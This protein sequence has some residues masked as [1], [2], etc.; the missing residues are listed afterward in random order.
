MIYEVL[1][2]SYF[3]AATISKPRPSSKLSFVFKSTRFSCKISV[4]LYFK[5][6]VLSNYEIA[7]WNYDID[8]S[9]RG[10]GRDLSTSSDPVLSTSLSIE[11]SS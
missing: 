3:E 7:V 5:R 1:S 6:C 2:K 4:A 11:A 9:D 10:G 8:E